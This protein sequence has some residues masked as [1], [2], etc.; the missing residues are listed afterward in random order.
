[1][2]RCALA[3]AD[4][5]AAAQITSAGLAQGRLRPSC[6]ARDKARAAVPA[7]STVIPG[8]GH[9]VLHAQE[10]PTIED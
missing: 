1:M 10:G 7:G 4:T 9:T 3:E 8:R 6:D 5:Q 2:G